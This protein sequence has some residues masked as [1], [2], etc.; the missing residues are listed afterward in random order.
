MSE[1]DLEL[2]ARKVERAVRLL[3]DAASGLKAAGYTRTARELANASFAAVNAIAE[4]DDTLAAAM[5]LA[6]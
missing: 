3:S 1:G 2:A 5:K 4:A 6:P